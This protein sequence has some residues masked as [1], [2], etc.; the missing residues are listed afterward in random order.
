MHIPAQYIIETPPQVVAFSL[1]NK[2]GMFATSFETQD[3]STFTFS[4]IIQFNKSVYDSAEYP[5]LKELY[6]K[7]ILTEKADMIF[8]K[9]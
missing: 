1:P 9:K 7:I 2:G 6:N 5:Y 3:N 4:N 8:K